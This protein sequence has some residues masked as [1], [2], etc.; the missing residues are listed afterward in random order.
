[1]S[2]LQISNFSEKIEI[3]IN[4]SLP[5]KYLGDVSL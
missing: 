3:H 2:L 4:A 5:M 1:M